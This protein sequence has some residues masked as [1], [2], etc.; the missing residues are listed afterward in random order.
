LLLLLCW[1]ACVLQVADSSRNRMLRVSFSRSGSSQPSHFF[2]NS[3]NTTYARASTP[4]AAAPDSCSN[5]DAPSNG[6]GAIGAQLTQQHLQELQQQLAQAPAP[7]AA[8]AAAAAELPAAAATSDKDSAHQQTDGFTKL[9]A[10]G[11]DGGKAAALL[12]YQPVQRDEIGKLQAGGVQQQGRPLRTCSTPILAATS[13]GVTLRDEQ[14]AAAVAAAAQHLRGAAPRAGP[15]RCASFQLRTPAAAAAAGGGGGAEPGDWR[16]RRMAG[17]HLQQCWAEEADWLADDGG[18]IDSLVTDG[19][20][21]TDATGLPASSEEG[22]EGWTEVETVFNMTGE[23]GWPACC[24]CVHMLL[25]VQAAC[26][27]SMRLDQAV[28]AC[29]HG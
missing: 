13:W 26:R 24:A 7:G 10:G 29:C 17:L 19:T 12:A 23:G 21:D 27:R 18:S 2:T 22:G 5:A 25:P 11:C 20:W 4:Q 15:R 1:V 16:L 8:A 14:E 9:G 6:D 3:C 28:A